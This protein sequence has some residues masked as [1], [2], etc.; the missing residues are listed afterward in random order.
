MAEHLFFAKQYETYIGK[1]LGAYHLDRLAEQL[2]TGP[3]FVARQA[4]LQVNRYYRLR[5]LALPT[6]LTP[7]ERLLYLGHFQRQASQLAS[8]QHATL[9]PLS[10]YGIF[11]GTPYLVAPDVS[12]R[13]LQDIVANSGPLEARLVGR[14]LD[15]I[16]TVLEYV[17]QQGVFHLNLNARTILVGRDGQPLL[18]ETGLVHLLAPQIQMGSSAATQPEV[19]LENGSSVLR[20]RRGK[21][22][23]GLGMASAPA[24]E[25]LLGQPLDASADVYALAALLYFMLTGHRIMRGRT[26][27]EMADQHLNAPVPSLGAWRKDLPAE[28]DHLLGSALAKSSTNRLRSPGTLANAYAGIVAPGQPERKA[29]AL[30]IAS[31]AFAHSVPHAYSHDAPASTTR[32]SVLS[33][34]RALT[35]LAAGG[36]VAAAAGMAVWAV[37]HNSGPATSV[38]SS[39]DNPASTKSATTGTGSQSTGSTS[40]HSGKVVAQTSD[41]PVNSAK[42]FPIANSDN[43]GVLIHLQNDR[44]VAFNSTCTHAGC[45]VAYNQQSH[46][47]ECP[48]H[49]AS[50]D[51]AKNASVVTGPASSPLAAIAVTVNQDGT[52]TTNG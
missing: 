5:F 39:G 37:G 1:T 13:T 43:P 47:L 23:Y 34:R 2:E 31:P 51:P 25:L 18:A 32:D 16:A 33:R 41:V 24:P 15:E 42:T 30:P 48:C 29:F 36:G 4:H 9:L 6:G 3:I 38:A 10:D 21:I 28:L 22:L 11:E 52:I 46:L 7:E 49:S 26:L 44:F 20:D 40:G 19:A 27:A 50:F 8:L 45:A 35:L 12:S 17:H 14:Y